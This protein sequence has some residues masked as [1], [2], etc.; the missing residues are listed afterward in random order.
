MKKILLVLTTLL[1]SA[2]IG[3]SQRIV[4]VDTEY[5]MSKIPGYEQ[6]QKS[7]DNISTNW[8][9][10]IDTKRTEIEQLYKKYQSEKVLL[11]DEMKSKREEEIIAKEKDVKDLQKKYFGKDGELFNKRQELIKPIQDEVYNA[12]KEMAIEGNFDYI[13]DKTTGA[14]LY[15]NDKYDKSDDIL[16]KLG[17]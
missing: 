1:F 2:T 3:Y 10:E 16:K 12:I 15:S 13:F 8:Q 7:L 9:K 14:I 6:A 5:I 4:H 17:Y 11:S